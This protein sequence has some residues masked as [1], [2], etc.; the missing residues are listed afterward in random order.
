MWKFQGYYKTILW[1]VN[2]IGSG[3]IKYADQDFQFISFNIVI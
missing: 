2:S 3:N 1:C